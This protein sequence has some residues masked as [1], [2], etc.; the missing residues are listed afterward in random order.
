M[1]CVREDHTAGGDP[2]NTLA[3][4]PIDGADAGTVLVSGSDFYA[5][6][7][8]S[9]DGSRLAWLKW[10]R[11]NMPWDGTELWEAGINPDGS[12]DQAVLVAGGLEES[13]F[14]PEWSP[15]GT[16]YFA[17]DRTGMVQHIPLA[18]PGRRGRMSHGRR[19]WQSTVQPG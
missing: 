9:P 18:R 10:D 6:P 5:S 7:R 1:V 19:V 13:I 11:P 14:Q 4:I 17:S 2:E 16:L 12:L 8:I 3:A 15:G